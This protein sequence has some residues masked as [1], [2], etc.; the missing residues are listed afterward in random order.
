MK[1]GILTFHWADN[2]GAMLQAYGL[3]QAVTKLGHSAYFVDYAPQGIRLPF[4]RGWGISK[5]AQFPA[6]ALQHLRFELFRRKHL[7]LTAPCASATVLEKVARGL[8]AVIV[9]S[10]Q[11][12]NVNMYKTF[13][14][15]YFLDF[16]E[17]SGCRRISYAACFGER[18]A[19]DTDVLRI[20]DLLRDFNSIS[21]RNELSR[22][23][24]WNLA[25]INPQIVLDPTFLHD[26]G[27][28]IS[29][30]HSS[31]KYIAA[32]FI[33]Y[34]QIKTARRMLDT[35]KNHLNLPVV[36]VGHDN[37][38]E[39]PS[40]QRM[41]SAGPIQWLNIFSNA[42]FI[43]SNSFHATIFS[44]KFRKPFIIWKSLRP[45]RIQHLVSLCGLESRLLADG[46]ITSIGKRINEPIDYDKV[47]NK[48]AAYI[49]T[50]R[51]FLEKALED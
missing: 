24:V 33:N 50:S 12:W 9:G 20:G 2:Y 15:A 23:L 22:E 42:A 37:M 45:E 32:Y 41:I 17:G 14:P 51:N 10:D 8:D 30:E 6:R 43:F 27:E 29:P 44:I 31:R 38:K 5:G 39:D 28:F 34:E 13:S 19:P 16:A 35:I 48:M 49:E 25:K 3:W 21:V 47:H 7:P 1:V 26:Y 40:E 11:V 18:S 4:W 46:D 36:F